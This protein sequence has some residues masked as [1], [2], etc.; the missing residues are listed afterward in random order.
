MQKFHI[1]STRP[2]KTIQPKRRQPTRTRTSH[3]PSQQTTRR[4]IPQTKPI[5]QSPRRTQPQASIPTIP[6]RTTTCRVKSSLSSQSTQVQTNTTR[7]QITRQVHNPTIQPCLLRP[8]A[9]KVHRTQQ[10]KRT[11]RQTK[12]A[13]TPRL[14]QTKRH[15]YQD[16][17]A[18]RI[19]PSSNTATHHN[20]LH[21]N[22]QDR[23]ERQKEARTLT[24]QRPEPNHPSFTVF[25]PSTYTTRSTIQK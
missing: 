2:R 6:Q 1:S 21:P 20:T 25:K 7:M 5:C 14:R 16:T 4:R 18:Q 11:V 12:T 9:T 15:T 10:S 19:Q 24:Q 23:K 13:T 17:K 22:I 3:L 8:K